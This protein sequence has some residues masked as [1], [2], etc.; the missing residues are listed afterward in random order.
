[1]QDPG[2]QD[3]VW[4]IERA[5]ALAADSTSRPIAGAGV[6]G[7][8]GL[9]ID[10][11]HDGQEP[12]LLE[13]TDAHARIDAFVATVS[14]R[15]RFRNPLA[16]T[17]EASYVFPLPHDAA[18]HE[19]VMTIGERR[20]RGIVRERDEA[21]RI[22]E[23]AKRHGHVASL[24]TQERPNVFT[25]KVANIEPGHR[26]DVEVRYFHTLTYVDG[27]YEYVFPMVVGPRF[28]PPGT[29]DPITGSSTEEWSS[30][31]GSVLGRYRG[32]VV[33][34]LRPE[35]RSGRDVSLAV[36]IDAGVAIEELESVHHGISAEWHGPDFVTATMNSQESIPNMDFVL[37]FR[38][39]GEHLKT[40]FMTH[41]DARGNFFALMLVP[42]ARAD[43]LARAPLE[44]VFVLDVSASMEGWPLQVSQE[45]IRRTLYRLGPDDTFQVVGFAD[46]SRSFRRQAVPATPGNVESGLTFLDEL[47][48]GGRTKMVQGIRTALGSP[49]DPRRMRI[50]TLFT[51]GFIGNEE[52]VFAVVRRNLGN[53]RLFSFGIGSSVNRHLLEELARV[54]RGAVAYVGLT[55]DVARAADRFHE[56]VRYPVLSHLDIDWGQM[57]VQDLQPPRLPDLFLGRPVIVTGRFEGSGRN[58]IHVRGLETPLR[59]RDPGLWDAWDRVSLPLDV[60]LD[61]PSAQHAGISL[62]WAR[63]AIQSLSDR[64]GEADPEV[65][66]RIRRLALT[67]GLVSRTTSFVTVDAS[68]SVWDRKTPSPVRVSRPDSIRAE[69]THGPR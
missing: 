19:F 28:S 30:G 52:E 60:D 26:I 44:M 58:R 12:L 38:V 27:W 37:R 2:L 5:P 23:R 18:I 20:I 54:G 50:V 17:I 4:I 25:Q 3:E 11:G 33:P 43:R 47:S 55:D 40:A 10:Y 6:P 24:L 67:F 66:A 59:G 46:D 36:E 7:C 57:R 64:R 29:P 53:A 42:P 14:V 8:G 16:R 21:Q 65:E 39:A 45:A 48:S 15:Q 63:R 22:Y 51:D 49:R 13:H 32:R 9:V 68:R 56:R 34:T 69:S 61:D 62:L 41:R 31:A 1:M 35:Q